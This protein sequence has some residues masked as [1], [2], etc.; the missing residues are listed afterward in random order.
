MEVRDHGPGIAPQDAERVFE[1]FYRGHHVGVSG[2][3]LGLPICRAIAEA[4]GG[5]LR[6]EAVPDGGACFRVT[7]PR[8]E[9]PPPE[10][11][12]EGLDL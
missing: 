11:L 4:H 10:P 12:P 7:L 2:A 8:P 3:G 6:V 9:T 5:T 1:K